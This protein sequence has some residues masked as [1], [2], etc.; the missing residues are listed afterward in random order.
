MLI[1]TFTVP[2]GSGFVFVTESILENQK[3]S[4]NISCVV[5]NYVVISYCMKQVNITVPLPLPIAQLYSREA[6]RRTRCKKLYTSRAAVMR[7]VLTEQAERLS[8]PCPQIPLAK[9]P[10]T[11]Q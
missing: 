6:K 3:K 10:A 11:S 7:E 9:T 1:D 8:T 2:F 4:S 5:T